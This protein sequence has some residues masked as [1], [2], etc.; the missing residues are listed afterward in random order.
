MS[1]PKHVG[2]LSMCI[3]VAPTDMKRIAK[4]TEKAKGNRTNA[5]FAEIC[6][7]NAATISRIINAK[8]KKNLSDDV[9]AAIVVNA[10]DSNAALF[11]EFLDAHGLVIPSAE[12]K[13]ES[14]QEQLYAEYL[15]QVRSALDMSRKTKTD[16]TVTP[17]ARREAIRT[18]VREIIQNYLIN[19]GYSVARIKDTDVMQSYDFPWSAD[20]VLKTNALEEE[21][22]D[23]WA[24]SI[25]EQSGWQFTREI[26][27]L[28]GMAYFDKPATNGFRITLV[29][30]D[31]ITFYETRKDLRSMG[32][33]YDSWSTLLVNTR[34][35]IVEA[36]Y[37]LEREVETA[38]VM[39][40]GKED[41]EIDW[42]EIYG[43]PDEV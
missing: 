11:R 33:A 35:G 42:Q 37:V 2:L 41:S 26:E 6:G 15:S 8:F 29:T 4:L 31:W 3:R 38:N 25:C 39:P 24:F 5:A 19:E 14:D 28:A 17:A 21:G 9:I 43:V 30:T 27:R 36:E 10:A 1:K 16:Q 22:L 18:R 7:V 13:S 23:K 20:F 40:T 32:P 12:G 34:K